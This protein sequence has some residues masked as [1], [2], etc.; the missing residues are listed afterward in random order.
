MTGDKS[1]F[2]TLEPLKD[3]EQEI[4]FGNKGALKATGIGMVEL[5][6]LTPVGE[7]VNTLRE[8]MFV[9]GVTENLFSVSRAIELGTEFVF[10]WRVCQV[11]MRNEV[12]L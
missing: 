3:G 4:K 11:F 8:V 5:R 2:K 6:C 1:L 7:R 12:V 9:L 10:K